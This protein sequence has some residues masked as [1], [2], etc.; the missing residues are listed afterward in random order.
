MCREAEYTI[1]TPFV[2]SCVRFVFA[3]A[4]DK[5][6]KDREKLLRQKMFLSASRFIL[7]PARSP[8]DPSPAPQRGK[9]GGGGS[10]VLAGT[11]IL[12]FL[13]ICFQVARLLVPFVTQLTRVTHKWT[14]S[15]TIV[16]RYR[17]LVFH[18]DAFSPGST[19]QTSVKGWTS[20]KDWTSLRDGT[21]R[22]MVGS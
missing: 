13:W 4:T 15:A 19:N 5:T 1:E 3:I 14:S 9:R 16:G 22:L 6:A 20:R 17:C 2:R 8:R 21:S 11:L 18:S 10:P 12:H 7:L